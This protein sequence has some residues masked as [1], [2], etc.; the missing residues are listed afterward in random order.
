MERQ[1]AIELLRSYFKSRAGSFYTSLIN[2]FFKADKINFMLL[3]KGFPM[4]GEV[5]NDYQ[6]GKIKF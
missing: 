3:H 4:L 6:V 1:E 2:A 5:I